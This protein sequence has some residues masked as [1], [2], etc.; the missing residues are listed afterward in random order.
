MNQIVSISDVINK[1]DGGTRQVFGVK[2]TA[3]VFAS[4]SNQYVGIVNGFFDQMVATAVFCL[5]IAH[6]TDKRNHYPTWVQPF[7]VG[8][9]F[10][11][12]G[13]AFCF[14]AG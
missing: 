6:I 5:M 14:N 3:H 13:T 8:T 9:S 1:F 2:A 10:V 12:V 7:L 4:Y 11:M